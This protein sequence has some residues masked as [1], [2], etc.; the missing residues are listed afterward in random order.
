MKD[1]ELITIFG[2]ILL[3]LFGLLGWSLNLHYM[4]IKEGQREIKRSI[5]NNQKDIKLNY[6]ELSGLA[7]RVSMVEK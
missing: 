7:A 4:D 5:E 1:K 2:V 6:R 3:L